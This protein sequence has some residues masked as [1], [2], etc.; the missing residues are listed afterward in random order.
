METSKTKT[1][2]TQ[3]KVQDVRRVETACS[4]LKRVLGDTLRCLA[5]KTRK[6]EAYLK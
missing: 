2:Q 4:T 5:E 1:T 3:E 6:T